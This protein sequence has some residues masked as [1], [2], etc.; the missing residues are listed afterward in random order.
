MVSRQNNERGKG[1]KGGRSRSTVVEDERTKDLGDSLLSDSPFLGEI[2][3]EEPKE[4]SL[5]FALSELDFRK[6][7]NFFFDALLSFPREL[8]SLSRPVELYRCTGT[9][10]KINAREGGK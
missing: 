2:R 6:K 8:R 5:E 3:E 4:P 9:R 7:E 1:R 10:P